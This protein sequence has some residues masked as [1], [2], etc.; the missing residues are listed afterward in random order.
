MFQTLGQAIRDAVPHWMLMFEYSPQTNEA[1]NITEPPPFDNSVYEIHLY[2]PS[3][4]L[5]QQI[6]ETS[7]NQAKSWN[8][9]MYLGEFSAFGATSPRGG[10]PDWPQATRDLLDYMKQRGM[11]WAV[12]GYAGGLS[13]IER[14]GQPKT[15]V[16]QALQ[17]GI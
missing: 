5:A 7:W 11:S 1:F 4:P 15:D 2:A 10:T 17:E 13:L 14:D 16:I 9:P 3:W 8:W 12:F 6:M